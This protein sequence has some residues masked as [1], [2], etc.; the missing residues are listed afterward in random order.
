MAPGLSLSGAYSGA[1]KAFAGFRL[2]SFHSA[3][4]VVP[5]R[6]SATVRIRDAVAVSGQCRRHMSLESV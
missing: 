6:F 5:A 1:L 2:Q 3:D 4:D